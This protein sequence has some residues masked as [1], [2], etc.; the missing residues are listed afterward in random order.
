MICPD[1]KW[2]SICMLDGDNE[3]CFT[4]EFLELTKELGSRTRS[5]AARLVTFWEGENLQTILDYFGPEDEEADKYDAIDGHPMGVRDDLMELW[6]Y[7]DLAAPDLDGEWYKDII[8]SKLIT[9]KLPERLIKEY[10]K[11]AKKANK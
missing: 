11:C 7:K 2:V 8:C 10:V 5:F 9:L 3:I 1:E 4:Q 6:S